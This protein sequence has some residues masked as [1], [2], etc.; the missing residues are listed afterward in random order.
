VDEIDVYYKH[1]RYYTREFKRGYRTELRY[2]DLSLGFEACK[3][4]RRGGG[5]LLFGLLIRLVHLFI[6]FI[7]HKYARLEIEVKH[8]T[9]VRV[10]V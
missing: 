8:G 4:R 9:I 6:L 2:N 3:G 5:A 7:G 10:M 1:S